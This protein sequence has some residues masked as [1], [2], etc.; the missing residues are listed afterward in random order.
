VGTSDTEKKSTMKKKRDS[1]ADGADLRRRAEDK[2]LEK[3]KSPQGATGG[4]M[5]AVEMQRLVQELQIHQIEL[6]TQN[7]ELKR[8]RD[9][10]E[11]ERERYLDLYDFAP[12]G[13]I[14]LASDGV[15][16]Q[17]NLTGARLLGLERSRLLNRRLVDFVAPA[18]VA[19]F[20]AFLKKVFEN[21]S[22]ESCAIFLGQ[23]GN[24]RSHVHIEATVTEEGRECRAA[25][26]DWT[27]RKKAQDEVLKLHG[28]L[29]QRSAEHI[30]QLEAANKELDSFSYSISHDLQTPLRA[31]DGYARMILRRQGD[32]FDEDTRSKFEVIRTNTQKMGKLITD[33]LT[34]SRLGTKPLAITTVDMDAVVKEAW[35][36]LK[37]V[38]PDRAMTMRIDGMPPGMGD[39][40]LISQVVANILSNAVKFAKF[41]DDVIVEMGGYEKESENVYYVKDNGVGFDMAYYDKLFGMFQRLHNPDEYEGTGVGLSIAQRIINRHGGRIWAEGKV[42][43]GATFYFSLP[44]VKTTPTENR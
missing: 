8:A 12:V 29:E 10:A 36:E 28:E 6:E 33:L 32:R 2:L 3:R 5:T 17:A 13:Y 43:K 1:R 21:G 42:D 22:K 38:H 41:R 9:E 25:I 39:R 16:R 27:E 7:E 11:S 20:D 23:E 37:T 19:A 4:R 15:I 35:V 14:T 18:D 26:L 30:S 44:K 40:A 31:I 24:Q 34:F